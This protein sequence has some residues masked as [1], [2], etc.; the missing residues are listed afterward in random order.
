MELTPLDIRK[1]EF[2]RKTIGGVDPAEVQGFLE[3]VAVEFERRQHEESDL[4]EKL[5][6]AKEQIAH[7]RSIELSLQEAAVTLQRTLE[8]KKV[9]A[10]READ[11][12]IA[13]AR[14]DAQRE[15]EMIRKESEKLRGEILQLHTQRTHFFV[16]FRSLLRSQWDL[17]EALERENGGMGDL[18]GEE[19]SPVRNRRAAQRGKAEQSSATSPSSEEPAEGQVE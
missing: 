10:H 1:Q 13:Q 2:R 19:E 18:K 15:T 17:L 8:E 5:K 12:I 9:D 16:R 6:Q 14:A 11:F 3:Q 4:Q 7:Y